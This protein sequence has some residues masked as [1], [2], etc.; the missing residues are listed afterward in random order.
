MYLIKIVRR[1]FAV[2]STERELRSLAFA[3]RE[4]QEFRSQLVINCAMVEAHVATFGYIHADGERLQK[5][6]AAISMI[7]VALADLRKQ[8]DEASALLKQLLAEGQAEYA[9][10]SIV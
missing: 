2:R 3:I 7:D 8:F 6:R 1:Y 9:V 10:P 5:L 4:H